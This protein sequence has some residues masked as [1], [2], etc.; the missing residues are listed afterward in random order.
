[1]D[2]DTPGEDAAALVPI[3][4][5]T[6]AKT[7]DENADQ[8]QKADNCLSSIDD[9]TSDMT[10]RKYNIYLQ[11]LGNFLLESLLKTEKM[12]TIHSKGRRMHVNK[13]HR[14]MKKV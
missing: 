11:L 1:M 14:F 2:T 10:L 12:I 8:N 6:A 4:G 9:N 7:N 13:M 3:T 5:P